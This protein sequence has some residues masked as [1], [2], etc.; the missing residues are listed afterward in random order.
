MTTIVLIPL[1]NDERVWSFV[2]PPLFRAGGN[3]ESALHC[4]PGETAL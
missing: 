2:R 3:G 4:G 1:M